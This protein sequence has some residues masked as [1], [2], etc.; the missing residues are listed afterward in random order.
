[1][2]GS[3]LKELLNVIYASLSVEKMLS[4]HAYAQ[5]IRGYLIVQLALANIILQEMD[6]NIKERETIRDICMTLIIT[7]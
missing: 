7:L 4:G 2:A 6:L 5:A 1:M 3:G